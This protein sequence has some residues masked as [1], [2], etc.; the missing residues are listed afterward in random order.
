MTTI[1][2]NRRFPSVLIGMLLI[3]ISGLFASF[4]GEA[5]V[6]YAAQ[7][8]TL[9]LEARFERPALDNWATIR[10]LVVLGGDPARLK[11]ALRLIRDHPHLRLVMSGWGDVE[12][13]LLGNTDATLRARIEIEQN[14]LSTCSNAV[15]S[16]QLIAPGPGDRWLLVTSA[17]H[18]PR[19]IG[20]FRKAGFPV[21]P[22][23][24]YEANAAPWNEV[25]HEWMGLAAYRLL[26]CSEAFLPG[27]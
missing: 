5:T 7:W 20:A 15:Y 14:S 4:Y 27:H 25:L 11:E 17:L 1:R 10:G 24:V 19:A 21:E 12:M 18:M 6:L 13:N 26:G 23:P 22:W 2:S 8:L 3:C 9:A 16:A